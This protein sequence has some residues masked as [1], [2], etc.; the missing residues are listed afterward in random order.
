MQVWVRGSCLSPCG[1]GNRQLVVSLSRLLG[2]NLINHTPNL[3]LLYSF[4][5]YIYEQ[6]VHWDN[7]AYLILITVLP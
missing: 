2:L 7:L 6:C 4:K 5:T 3:Q 1:M